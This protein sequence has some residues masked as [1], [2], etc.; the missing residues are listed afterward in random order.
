MPAQLY[1]VIIVDAG[2]G[3]L[4]G[5]L[6]RTQIMSIISSSTRGNEERPRSVCSPN[7]HVFRMISTCFASMSQMAWDACARVLLV[8]A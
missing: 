5:R 3:G 6:G 8:N 4:S 2:L 7:L 1:A